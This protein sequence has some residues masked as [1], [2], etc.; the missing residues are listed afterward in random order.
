MIINSMP[1][2]SM[3]LLMSVKMAHSQVPRNSMEFQGTACVG[4]IGAQQIPQNSTELLV[5]AKLTL[6][7]FHGMSWNLSFY[8]MKLFV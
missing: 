4:E 1:R 8:L 5:S 7:K 2:N 3:E 6:S